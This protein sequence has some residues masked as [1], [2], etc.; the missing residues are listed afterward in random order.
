MTGVIGTVQPTHPESPSRLCGSQTV[1]ESRVGTALP[2]PH[3]FFCPHPHAFCYLWDALAYSCQNQEQSLSCPSSLARLGGGACMC[4]H[5]H[6]C[7]HAHACRTC[8]TC[9]CVCTGDHDHTHIYTE[10][11]NISMD[12][13]YNCVCSC[14]HVSVLH[15]CM[16]VYVCVYTERRKPAPSGSLSKPARPSSHDCC[17]LDGTL[18]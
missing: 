2:F 6:V 12:T 5:V 17:P 10:S 1:S 9:V 8:M 11:P 7:E 4:V 15:V 14:A 16:Y 3:L 18:G 13:H